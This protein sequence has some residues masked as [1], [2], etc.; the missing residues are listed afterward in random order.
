MTGSRLLGS[1]D[2]RRPLALFGGR[3]DPVHRAH[4][5]IAQAVADTLNLNEVHWIVTG[6]PKHK[7]VVASPED[8]L[9]MVK[10]ALHDLG[11][12]RMEADDREIIAAKNG[13]SNYTADTVE[14]IQRESPGRKLIW[15]LGEDQLQRIHS[16]SRWK[17]L[18]H[19]VSFAVCTRSD[20]HSGNVLVELEKHGAEIRYIGVER[21]TVSSTEIRYRIRS[22][23]RVDELLSRSVSQYISATG[24]YR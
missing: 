19:Q 7:P 21:D 2:N 23:D 6:E 15:I 1:K 4:T 16:W 18:I 5:A 17:W 11:D 20:S 24:L 3:F 13:C 8:R 14:A 10:L 22:G 12:H 9:H